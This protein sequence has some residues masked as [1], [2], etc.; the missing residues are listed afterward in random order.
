MPI[1]MQI[2]E[3][4]ALEDP[5]S[6]VGRVFSLKNE[7]MEVA[8]RHFPD[9]SGPALDALVN[10]LGHA[11]LV[12]DMP[13]RSATARTC[14]EQLIRMVDANVADQALRQR[15]NERDDA[16]QQR[17]GDAVVKLLVEFEGG[18][19]DNEAILLCINLLI[20][21]VVRSDDNLQLHT[22]AAAAEK[23]VRMCDA[24]LAASEHVH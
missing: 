2:R 14:A 20:R 8:F 22:I 4:K 13:D 23:I 18:A 15:E 6:M 11:I 5:T 3:S 19:T 1:P 21:I 12:A 17:L 9:E 16:R 10:A 24:Q 7:L